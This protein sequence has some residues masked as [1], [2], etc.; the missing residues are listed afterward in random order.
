MAILSSQET[1]L[2]ILVEH[3]RFHTFKQ[4]LLACVLFTKNSSGK[5][6]PQFSLHF[7]PQ[8]DKGGSGTF[9]SKEEFDAYKD[10][11]RKHTSKALFTYQLAPPSE[12][13]AAAKTLAK[14]RKMA[15]DVWKRL[16]ETYLPDGESA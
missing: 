16:C 6:M 10:F 3:S 2:K 7:H 15:Y 14:K 13:A 11:E 9:S 4:L 12:R 8:S 1:Y 5:L